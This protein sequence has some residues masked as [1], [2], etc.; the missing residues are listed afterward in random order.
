MNE[1]VHPGRP[2]LDWAGERLRPE[3]TERLLSGKLNY[4]PRPYFVDRM[5]AFPR[6]A[7]G[8]AQGLSAQ[9]GFPAHSLESPPTSFDE[10]LARTGR[11][12][13]AQRSG[14]NCVACH[15]V[16]SQR[17]L[18]RIDAEGINFAKVSER[19]RKMHYDRYMLDPQRIQPGTKMPQFMNEDG[20]SNHHQYF[21]GDGRKQINSFWH[22]FVELSQARNT[23][24]LQE[25]DGP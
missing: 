9:H 24:V 25:I 15:A 3:W 1:P 19:L 23:W 11:I 5:P 16:G 7:E 6:Y 22:F 12:L 21:G 13:A 18:A 14:F 2:A 17:P 10:D 8:I 4:K 20:T